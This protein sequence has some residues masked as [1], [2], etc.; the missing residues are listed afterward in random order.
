MAAA[1]AK[2]CGLRVD[3]MPEE[4][5]VPELVDALAD[6]VAGLRAAGQLPPPRKTRK[7]SAKS[8]AK[9]AAKAATK[10]SKSTSSKAGKTDDAS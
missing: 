7:R 2:E 6:H 10:S 8:A 3:V 9:S 1:T 5:G 4:A